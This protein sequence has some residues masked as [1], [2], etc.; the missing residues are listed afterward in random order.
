[1]FGVPNPLSQ[2]Q[3]NAINT[4]QRY[5]HAYDNRLVAVVANQRIDNAQVSRRSI[6]TTIPPMNPATAPT[7]LHPGISTYS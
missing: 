2:R 5:P 4:Q 6:K 1:M 3:R 7:T